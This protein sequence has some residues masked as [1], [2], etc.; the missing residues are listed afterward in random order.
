MNLIVCFGIGTVQSEC[1]RDVQKRVR[2][3][4]CTCTYV[5]DIVAILKVPFYWLGT[6]VDAAI[7]RPDKLNKL[8]YIMK[9]IH[10]QFCGLLKRNHTKR[11][12]K[13]FIKTEPGHSSSCQITSSSVEKESHR[14]SWQDLHT[15]EPGHSTSCQL[16]ARPVK[17]ALIAASDL[18]LHC[19]SIRAGH[20]VAN[21][22]SKA[23]SR[24]QSRFWS[25]TKTNLFKYW[26]VYHQKNENFQMKVRIFFIFLLKT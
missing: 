13:H 12:D 5:I 18:D 25:I 24:E 23:S 26:N 6:I 8:M 9:G 3:G 20:H 10:F 1:R 16:H 19:L 4:V 14:M 22:W 7:S 21:L 15:L 11:H 2:V 17:T